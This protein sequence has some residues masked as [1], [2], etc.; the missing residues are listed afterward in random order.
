MKKPKDEQL[1]LGELDSET[2]EE[3]DSE[4]DED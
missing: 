1:D 3:D 4:S 2:F